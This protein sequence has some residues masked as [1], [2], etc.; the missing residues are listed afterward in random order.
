[1]ECQRTKE[2]G[3]YLDDLLDLFFVGHGPRERGHGEWVEA[4]LG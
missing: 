1:M 3:I 2:N 4:R